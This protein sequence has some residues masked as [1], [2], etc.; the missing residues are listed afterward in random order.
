M[1]STQC[2]VRHQLIHQPSNSR[3]NMSSTVIFA[4]LSRRFTRAL[5]QWVTKSSYFP[6]H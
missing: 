5:K 1:F 6:S 3:A 4:P 2:L